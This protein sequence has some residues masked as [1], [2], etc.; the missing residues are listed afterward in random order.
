MLSYSG[1]DRA[2]RSSASCCLVLFE[3]AARVLTNKA[4]ELSKGGGYGCWARAKT[5]CRQRLENPRTSHGLDKKFNRIFFL[6]YCINKIF[7]SLMYFVSQGTPTVH[8]VALSRVKCRELWER[9]CV[10]QALS[11]LSNLSSDFREF[12]WLC[13]TRITNSTAMVLHIFALAAFSSIKFRESCEPTLSDQ[14]FKLVWCDCEAPFLFNSE[15]R[16][17]E[18]LILFLKHHQEYF[19]IDCIVK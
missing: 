19:C 11:F 15:L 6:Q 7:A 13:F 10:I 12:D 1:E 18:Y 16:L 3:V 8:L 17:L 9:L 2:I 4:N 5:S 14:A